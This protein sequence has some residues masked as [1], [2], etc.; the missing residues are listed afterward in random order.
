MKKF[1][2]FVLTQPDKK[3]TAIV[4]SENKTALFLKSG[5][6][7]C[8]YVAQK[9]FSDDTVKIQYD[10]DG[11]I[12]AVVDKPVPQRGNVYAASML[13]PHNASVAEITVDDY[14]EGVQLDGTWRFDGQTV[15]RDADLVAQKALRLNTR[16][17]ARLAAQAA[18]TIATLQN[19][20]SIQRAQDGDIYALTAW[21]HYLVNLDELRDVDL[22]AENPA[23]PEI[24]DFLNPEKAQ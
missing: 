3:V 13:W 14:P 22:S 11:I 19:R 2:N 12:R 18:L 20:I 5:N 1:E 6:G 21:Q 15:Y 17:R 9:K 4:G 8:W 10:S 23:W 24:P 16:K 7:L